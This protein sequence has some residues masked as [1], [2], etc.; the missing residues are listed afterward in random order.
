[1]LRSPEPD[2]QRLIAARPSSH[3]PGTFPRGYLPPGEAVLFETRPSLWAFVS[4][5][6]VAGV[7]LA[8][9]GVL[10]WLESSSLST[11]FA[12]G[13][14]GQL[15][16]VIAIGLAVLAIAVIVGRLIGWYFTSYAISNR[17][18]IRKSG[19]ASRMI[20]DARFEKIQCV[21]LTDN[22]GSRVR[23]FGNILYSLST[24]SSP[25]FG[26]SGVERGGIL[27]FA[28]P[29]PVQVRAFVEDIF[30]TFSRFDREGHRIILEE[31]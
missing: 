18:V 31:T 11:Y 15:W 7:F 14:G 17:R 6:L 13:S 21:T 29:D 20:I 2:I 22:V 24:S 23:G 19:W 12:D 27:W 8:V 3:Q 28:I 10:V 9:I 4:G 16:Q 26:L 30:E 25:T 1:V 5:G